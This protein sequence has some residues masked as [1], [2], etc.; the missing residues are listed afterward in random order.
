MAAKILRNTAGSC[1]CASPLYQPCVSYMNVAYFSA[2]KGPENMPPGR[3]VGTK[4]DWLGAAVSL[5]GFES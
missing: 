3:E 1:G 2:I 5:L 4:D